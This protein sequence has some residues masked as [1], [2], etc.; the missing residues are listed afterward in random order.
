MSES[1][2]NNIY[3][4]IVQVPERTPEQ[5]QFLAEHKKYYEERK[6]LGDDNP[7]PYLHYLK[8]KRYRE[9]LG[10]CTCDPVHVC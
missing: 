1:L 6:A 4:G 2:I 8:R 10:T 5:K 3:R 9:M 7:M